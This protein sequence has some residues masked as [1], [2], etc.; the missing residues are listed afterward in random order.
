MASGERPRLGV[1]KLASCDGC[2]LTLLDCEDELLAVAGAVEIVR[3]AEA[4]CMGCHTTGFNIEQ[5]AESPHWKMVGSALPEQPGHQTG[6][7][8]VGCERCHGPGS[9]H[10]EAAKQKEAQGSKLDPARDQM[11]ILTL[12]V[13]FPANQ[14]LV[15]EASADVVEGGAT[16]H[17][18]TCLAFM[19]A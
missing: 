18:S 11:W 8:A 16:R 3:F 9:K 10:I 14:A 13:A 12:G 4:K 19:F 5:G 15:G 1:F 2:Q 6:E 7:L 17:E